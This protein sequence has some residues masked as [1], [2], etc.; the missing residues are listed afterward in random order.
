VKIG[1]LRQHR[2]CSSL[3]GPR[4]PCVLSVIKGATMILAHLLR[5]ADGRTACAGSSMINLWLV[6]HFGC[7]FHHP[8]DGFGT[9]WQ[10]DLVATPIVYHLQKLYA[11]VVVHE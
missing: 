7:Q 8:P 5:N 10:V 11:V 9:R 6:P 3:F 1:H 2:L 4:E